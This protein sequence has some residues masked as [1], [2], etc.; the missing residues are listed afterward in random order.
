MLI[1]ASVYNGN[2]PIARRV[3]FY[4]GEQGDDHG[5]ESVEIVDL[6][7]VG[8]ISGSTAEVWELMPGI[9]TFRRRWTMNVSISIGSVVSLR[10]FPPSRSLLFSVGDIV[11]LAGEEGK[12]LG[13][14]PSFCRL[15]RAKRYDRIHL[16]SLS[17]SFFQ[18]SGW[19]LECS[20]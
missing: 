7:S 16:A 17:L 6:H 3:W 19:R 14:L 12:H 20:Y 13:Q 11:G 4:P 8:R 1:R 10:Q 9:L 15:Q 2:A 18:P 5:A